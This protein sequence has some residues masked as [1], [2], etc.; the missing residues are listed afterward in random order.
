M[1]ADIDSPDP[2][3]RKW[4]IKITDV[5]HSGL[6]VGEAYTDCEKGTKGYAAT[7]WRYDSVGP[8]AALMPSM[9]TFASIGAP[10]A[11]WFLVEELARLALKLE[12]HGVSLAVGQGTWGP[13]RIDMDLLKPRL[14]Q[15]L[16]EATHGYAPRD[17][18]LG[19]AMARVTC[20]VAPK[21][22]HRGPGGA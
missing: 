2:P 12:H 18:D 20:L 1:T 13:M 8:N 10:V 3:R 19:I 4:V 21:D 17:S 9:G 14:E 5:T 22:H 16:Y 7:D 6:V 11:L 15:M